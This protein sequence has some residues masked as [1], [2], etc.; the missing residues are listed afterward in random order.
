MPTGLGH[1]ALAPAMF[2]GGKEH[3]N[4]AAGSASVSVN[5]AN[6][7]ASQPVDAACA[8]G[9]GHEGAIQTGSGSSARARSRA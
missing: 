5:H 8:S 1:E 6:Y 2:E 4:T 9:C 7:L 3:D